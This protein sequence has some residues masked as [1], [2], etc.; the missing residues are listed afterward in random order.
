MNTRQFEPLRD[1]FR[2]V[3]II[4][5]GGTPD[6]VTREFRWILHDFDVNKAE[7]KPDHVA[8][9]DM[10]IGQIMLPHAEASWV[11]DIIGPSKPD[12]HR[13]PQPG[14]W[15]Q[16]RPDRAGLPPGPWRVGVSAAA[17][18]L[19]RNAAAIH[20]SPWPGRAAEPQRRDRLALAAESR[21]TTAWIRSKASARWHLSLGLLNVNVGIILGGQYIQGE[22]TKR[23]PSG[24]EKKSV[25]VLL[26]GLDLSGPLPFSA[27]SSPLS[28]DGNFE[29]DRAVNWDWFNLQ[30]VGFGG[31]ELSVGGTVNAS[32]VT[33]GWGPNGISIGLA[34]VGG[35][36]PTAGAFLGAGVMNVIGI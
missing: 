8:R 29:L 18:T 26:L 32:Y 33:I 14:A 20:R 21:H 16:P 11:V 19:G 17:G 13:R 6:K 25:N 1:I 24:D 34:G 7:L 30:F 22:L 36:T 15:L 5:D 31:V 27:T 10:M 9:L 35:G 12:R 23:L 3:L 28:T 2:D 4:L